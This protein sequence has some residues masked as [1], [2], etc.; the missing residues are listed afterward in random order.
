MLSQ[1]PEFAASLQ[2]YGG[3]IA[4]V[5]GRRDCLQPA[6]HRLRVRRRRPLDGSRRGRAA[7][8]AGPTAAAAL[9]PYA[10]G[11]YVN[12]LTDEGADGVRR[13]YPPAKFARLT[14]LKARYDPDNVFHLNQ[15]IA[16]PAR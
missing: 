6:R 14:E 11:V 3:A 5:A 13:A 12:V 2:T 9:A 4:D 1:P 16:P 15:N 7:D 10:S 8:R